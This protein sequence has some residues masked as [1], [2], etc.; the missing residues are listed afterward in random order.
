MTFYC[1]CRWG[2]FIQHIRHIN[3]NPLITRRKVWVGWVCR[4]GCVSDAYPAHP[5]FVSDAHP[6]H[7]PHPTQRSG[8]R[9]KQRFQSHN[10]NVSDVSDKSPLCARNGEEAR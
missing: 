1:S 5:D 8:T 9:F 10:A 6:T 3:A 4:I 7:T 2:G